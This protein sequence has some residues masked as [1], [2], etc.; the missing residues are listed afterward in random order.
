MAPMRLFWE[1]ARLSF[2]R[3]LTYRAANFAGLATNLFFGLLRAAVLIAFYGARQETA[4]LSIG[5]AVTFTGISQ[6][7]I[8]VLSLFSWFD[9]ARAVYTGEIASDLLKPAGYFRFWMAQDLGRAAGAFLL[10]SLPLMAVYALVFP[11]S[12]PASPGQWIAV[13][14]A[15]VLAWMCS[16]T[17]RFLINLAAFWTPDA[18]GVLRFAFG[19]SWV[20]SGF[21]MPLLFFPDW[22][23]QL[24]Y[25]TPFPAM[26]NTVVE[27]Y[28]GVRTGPAAVQALLAQAAWIVALAALA[29]VVLR[30]GVRRLV[31]QGG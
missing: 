17:W 28:L 3:Q 1:L 10:R 11:I 13:A 5:A 27:I 21:A 29:Q 18:Q 7:A 26:I 8:G 12:A 30:L 14:L 9:V 31:I 23:R 2:Q 22:F 20:L 19:L 6:A 25:L 24:C 16:F 4:G 15:I